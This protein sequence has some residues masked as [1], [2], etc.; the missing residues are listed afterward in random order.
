MI[1]KKLQCSKSPLIQIL[2][3]NPSRD[4]YWLS[5]VKNNVVKSVMVIPWWY[6]MAD[7]CRLP[8]ATAPVFFKK[9][10]RHRKPCL[11]GGFWLASHNTSK[12]KYELIIQIK[13]IN[14]LSYH[15]IILK[16]SSTLE[17]TR[18]SKCKVFNRSMRQ[19]FT[20][21]CV[22]SKIN[23]KQR[24]YLSPHKSGVGNGRTWH[25]ATSPLK[26]Y[27]GRSESSNFGKGSRVKVQF[28]KE[29][30]IVKIG[31]QERGNSYHD[32]L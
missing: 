2:E 29:I 6:G 15:I 31:F 10:Q 12:A 18:N 26:C 11:Y 23:R 30:C 14:Q 1:K 32:N 28:C 24:K 5:K 7:L 19:S 25:R 4:N 16:T 17:K 3:K 27:S 20:P 13:K 9:P 8:Q 21:L 22:P